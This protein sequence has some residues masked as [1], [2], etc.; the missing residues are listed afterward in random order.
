MLNPSLRQQVFRAARALREGGVIA[1]PTEYC[2]GLG[3][4]PRDTAAMQK[5][6]SIKRRQAEQ[7][8]ILIAADLHQVG[9]YADLNSVADITR[10]TLSWPGP[11]TWLLPALDGISTLVRG[12]HKS[13]AMRI[14][15]HDFCLALLQEFGHPIVSTS[16]NRS[17]EKEHLS[18]ATC[19]DDL[20][21]E[22]DFIVDAP[23][24]GATRASAIRDALTGHTL[25]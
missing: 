3:C 22:C 6:L 19:E 18:A 12:K 1:Y 17:G 21:V 10:I 13:I 7:G 5:L 24:G 15:D 2:F 4:D 14:P 16:A 23:V 11:T 20:G 9:F 8:V 25:R